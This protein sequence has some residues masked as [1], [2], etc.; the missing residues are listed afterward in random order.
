MRNLACGDQ[1]ILHVI[2]RKLVS[3]DWVHVSPGLVSRDGE[4][5]GDC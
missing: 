5:V 1:Y 3:N 4:R 2:L